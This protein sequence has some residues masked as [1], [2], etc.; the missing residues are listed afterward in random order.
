M[1]ANA[2][3][4]R[5]DPVT[6]VDCAIDLQ[7]ER[8]GIRIRQTT[9]RTRVDAGAVSLGA[10]TRLTPPASSSS[11]RQRRMT[12]PTRS[13]SPG[14]IR[15][16]WQAANPRVTDRSV[17]KEPGGDEFARDRVRRRGG[18]SRAQPPT[19][20]PSNSPG[21]TP[22]PCRAGNPARTSTWCCLRGASAS[23]RCFPRPYRMRRPGASP[24]C[25]SRPA[26]AGRYGCMTRSRWVTSIR[27]LGP[28][29]FP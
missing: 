27:V 11:C 3:T 2:L 25:V 7:A 12:R 6:T 5:E 24:C 15:H 19:R 14:G 16:R 13:T 9:T 21:R 1:I 23:I 18:G 29:H 10:R 8:I 22:P 26:G 20:S 17:A 28:R 4:V